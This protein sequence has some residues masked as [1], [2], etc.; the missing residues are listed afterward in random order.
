MQS[1]FSEG[2]PLGWILA[3]YGWWDLWKRWIL[4][5]EYKMVKVDEMW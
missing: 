1:R 5:L 4:S 3:V 2:N